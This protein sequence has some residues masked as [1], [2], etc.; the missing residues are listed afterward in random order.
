MAR[1]KNGSLVPGRFQLLQPGTGGVGEGGIVPGGGQAQGLLEMLNRFTRL[2]LSF[3]RVAQRKLDLG[4]I[5]VALKQPFILLDG[6]GQFSLPCQRIAQMEAGFGIIRIE[7]EYPRILLNRFLQLALGCQRV[8]Q[9]IAGFGRI[10]GELE[11]LPVML[12][13]FVRFSLLP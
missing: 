5:G 10:R 1:G 8:A 12:D 2:A 9:I 11:R 4:G 7:L 6:L 13:G 3:Q